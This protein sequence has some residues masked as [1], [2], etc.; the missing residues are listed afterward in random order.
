MNNAV[1]ST[2]SEDVSQRTSHKR[3]AEFDIL[4]TVS[5]LL[6]VVAHV[7]EQFDA[8]IAQDVMS[9]G[10]WL[11]Y[12][13]AFIGPSVLMICLGTNLSFSKRTTPKQMAIRGI[14]F[15]GIDFVLNV[16]RFGVPTV[17]MAICGRPEFLPFFI[18]QILCSD[19]Y[20]FVGAVFILYALFKKCNLSFRAILSVSVVMLTINTLIDCFH[21]NVVDNRM[22]AAFLGRFFWMGHTSYFSLF[23]WFI[24]PVIGCGFGEF[25]KGL[26]TDDQNKYV[27]QLMTVCIVGVI[28]LSAALISNGVSPLIAVISLNDYKT[29][30]LS[31]IL[32]ILLGGIAFGVAHVFV[33]KYPESLWVKLSIKAS[34][35]IMPFYI[36]QWISIAWIQFYLEAISAYD[37]FQNSLTVYL[38]AVGIIIISMYFAILF[39]KGKSKRKMR[40][41]KS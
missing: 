2:K 13:Y 30:L 24:F 6:M 10:S 20:A 18:E 3:Y 15:L 37:H 11:S 14:S 26:T 31:V 23:P 8:Y 29:D 39:E 21:L 9:Q 40:I 22:L 25:Y 38:F 28:A 1:V 4:R 27:S 12:A 41:S 35:V 5:M 17:T 19:I 36:I 34:K 16:I 7:W 33:A 32:M